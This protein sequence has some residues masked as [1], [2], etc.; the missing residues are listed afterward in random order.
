[1]RAEVTP[2]P[3]N[4]ANR[5]PKA[6]NSPLPGLYIHIPFCRTKCPY[7]D[8]YSVT[9]LSLI[10]AWLEA[11]QQ[12]VLLYQD[13]FPPFDS[14]YLGGGTPSLLPDGDLATLMDSLRFHFRFAP[15]PE[16]TL[17]ANP[18]DL[19][20]ARLARLQDL[21]VNRLSLGVQSFVEPE[22]SFLGRRHTARQTEQALEWVRAA[23]FDNLGLD[24]MYAL[25]GQS[26]AAWTQTLKKALK[27]RPEHLSCYQLTLEPDTQMC[28]RA[29]ARQITPLTEEEERALFLLTSRFL[30]ERGYIHYEVSNFARGE[31]YFSRHN[32][33]YWHH[34]PYLGLGPAAHSFAAGRR[35]WNHRSLSQYCQALADGRPPVAGSENL[36]PEQLQLESLYLGFRTREGVALDALRHHPRWAT[37][38]TGLQKPGLVRLI[39]G[40]ARATRQGLAV[41]DRLALGFVD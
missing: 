18:D 24:L 8:F 29:A 4:A 32:R 40:R 1:M 35:W 34:V 31:E 25:P 38:L 5:K 2:F 19:S 41:A 37:V 16:I 12:E 10:P 11:V 33:K 14:L 20:P 26:Q 27:Y 39:N 36:T 30:E 13:T 17:E 23:E 28:A 15:D 6:E 22:L 9:S 21:G 7:C 3:E